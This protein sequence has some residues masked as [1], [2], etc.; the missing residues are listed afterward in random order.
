MSSYRTVLAWGREQLM[1]H[2]ISDG[3]LDAWYLL[4]EVSG[5]DRA[6]Y[7]LHCEEEMP[8]EQEEIY[9]RWI[10]K[11]SA[12]IPLQHI[13]GK[14]WFMGR[15]FI[16]SPDVLVPR[17]DT[18]V[19]AEEAIRRLTPGMRILDMC[20]GS[21]CILLSLLAERADV[22]GVGADISSAALRVAGENAVR[23]E[24]QGLIGTDQVQ[25]VCGDLFEPVTGTFSMIVSNPPYIP[26]EVIKGLMPEV[27]N[28]DPMGAL[29]GGEDGLDFYRRIIRQSASCL[30]PGGWLLFEIGYDQGEQVSALMKTQKFTEINTI[31]DLAGLDRVV[32][33]RRPGDQE[34]RK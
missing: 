30:E 25:W 13:T 32:L 9:H 27:R 7:F 10:S 22:R 12:H 2:R 28:H 14:A 3:E 1:E 15:E 26:T 6:S 16:V 34:E 24:Q 21:G 31:K 20:T 5:M 11:R 8:Q 17:Q 29:D 4:E 23:M 18:E 33:G 19:L